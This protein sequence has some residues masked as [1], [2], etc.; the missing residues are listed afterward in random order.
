MGGACPCAMGKKS[1]PSTSVNPERPVPFLEQ[2]CSFCFSVGTCH[3]KLWG[4]PYHH[5][6]PPKASTL[7]G[8]IQSLPGC[9]SL[10]PCPWVALPPL[11]ALGL[12]AAKEAADSTGNWLCLELSLGTGWS[13]GCLCQSEWMLV[14]PGKEGVLGE[15]SSK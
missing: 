5:S 13:P 7:C 2:L 6:L 1:A 10:C 3:L 8:A 14:L 4:L 11:P 12:C 9:W 15:P